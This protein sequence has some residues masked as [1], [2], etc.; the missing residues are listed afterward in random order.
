MHQRKSQAKV[1]VPGVS[2]NSIKEEGVCSKPDRFS[3]Q[4]SYTL[5]ITSLWVQVCRKS[6]SP[7]YFCCHLCDW[8][9]V[10]K[11]GIPKPSFEAFKSKGEFI[12]WS[13]KQSS[14]NFPFYVTDFLLLFVLSRKKSSQTYHIWTSEGEFERFER[15]L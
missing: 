5:A 12:I 11:K 14:H 8:V 1:D 9:F 13:L 7:M 15:K 4:N 2:R 6:H 10:C 3:Q